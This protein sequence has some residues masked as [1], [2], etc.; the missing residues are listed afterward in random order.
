MRLIEPV[1]RR[2]APL[3]REEGYSMMAVIA[4]IA[5]TTTLVTAA[6][7]AS[8]GDQGLLRH[9]IDQKR[10]YLAAQ[11]GVADYTYHLN[12]DSGYWARCTSVP[13]PNAVN[14]NMNG[15]PTNFRPVPGTTDG[16]RYGIEL[17]QASSSPGGSQ[18]DAQ[19]PNATMLEANAPNTGTFRIRS[20]GYSGGGKVS[21]V[22]TYKQATFLDYVYFT[23]LETSDPV[24][25]GFPNPSA[26]LTGAYS[27]CTKFRRDGRETVNIPGTTQRCDQIVFVSGDRIDGPLHTNDDLRVCGTPTFGRNG[28]DVTEVSAPPV[29]W[30]SGN[31]CTGTPTFRAPLVTRAPVL[32]PPA[33]NTSL[34][35][36]AGPSYTFTG[37]TKIVLNGTNMTITTSTGQ[38]I[39]PM[40]VPSDGVVYVQNG[41]GCSN[42]YSPFTVTYPATSGCGNAIVDTGSSSYSGQLTIA[43]ENDVII[44]GNIR[45][46]SSSADLL[47]LIANNFI[48]VKHPVC[49]SSD[50][51]CAGGTGVPGSVSEES[52]K[53][54]CDAD[55][56]NSRAVNGNGSNQ[57]LTIDAALLSIDHSFIV[58]HYDCGGSLG[59]LTVNGAISQKFRGAVGTTGEPATSRTTTTT[60]VSASR[61]RRTS[62]TRCSRPG[63]SSGRR[64][65]SGRVPCGLARVRRRNAHRELRRRRRSSSAPGPLDRRTSLGVRLLRRSDSCLRQRPGD[66]LAD[67]ARSL[68]LLSRGDPGPLP[69]RGARRRRCLCRYGDCSAP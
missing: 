11:S 13:T 19:N 43:A 31:S 21:I 46:T 16:S 35:A 66:L 23:Q 5:L 65:G 27:Q 50:L 53:G 1:M 18:C 20:T 57:D 62:S 52:A 29:G 22:T 6:V 60:T 14:L 64:W 41:A 4:A 36:F 47:G 40:S 28:A 15:N 45:R 30:A 26:A 61:S 32:T 24:T 7:A 42:S 55:N 12:T 56:D 9:D 8:N 2:L 34:K 39:G 25:Y 51:N 67:P 59:T 54:D 48:R 68:P 33:T 17:L 3:R 63:T 10:A 44:D 38:T 49:E 58:D 37:Q 69:A